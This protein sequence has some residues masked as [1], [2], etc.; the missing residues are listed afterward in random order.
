MK[1]RKEINIAAAIIT[2]PDGRILLVRKRGTPFFMQPGG[3]IE[4]GESSETALIRELKEELLI[5]VP[6]NKLIYIGRFEDVAPNEP[7][8]VVV[9]DMFMVDLR[10]SSVKAAAEIEEVLWFTS[11]GEE[12]LLAPLTE[13]Q[14]IPLLRSQI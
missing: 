14:I 2:D 6:A 8:H 12:K 7:G 5:A 3:K 4:P 9:A 11:S 10:I 13:N 1:Q